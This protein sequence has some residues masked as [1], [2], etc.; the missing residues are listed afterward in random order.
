MRLFSAIVPPPNVLDHLEQAL[1]A[2]IPPR[3]GQRNPRMP[4]NT[5]HVTLAFYGDLPDALADG[6]A[7]D[8]AD[9]ARTYAPFE[10]A[11]SGSGTFGGTMGWIGVGGATTTLKRLMTDAAGVLG[12]ESEE[13]S[14]GQRQHPHLTISRKVRLAKLEPALKALAVYRGP[15]W[16]VDALDL[17][18][19]DLGHGVGGHPLY[20]T[21]ASVPL[22]SH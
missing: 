9:I 12:G 22:G 1:D 20:T 13:E 6:I 4:R 17:I 10:L 5:W 14:T 7:D 21:I 3:A 15:T 19:S 16:T 8:L 2:V 11:L 18:E